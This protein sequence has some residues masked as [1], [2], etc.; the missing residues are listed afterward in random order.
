MEEQFFFPEE[1]MNQN[2]QR[3]GNSPVC[4][5]NLKMIYFYYSRGLTYLIS[6]WSYIHSQES[7][8]QIIYSIKLQTKQL[9]HHQFVTA[10]T[11]G[12]NGKRNLIFCRFLCPLLCSLSYLT[13]DKLVQLSGADNP[14]AITRPFSSFKNNTKK[15][16]EPNFQLCFQQFLNFFSK[17]CGHQNPTTKVKSIN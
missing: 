11:S 17:P 8:A 4:I 3:F 1:K 14:N 9:Q 12:T 5:I 10:S 16:I 15:A 13:I 2:Y 6:D 7:I